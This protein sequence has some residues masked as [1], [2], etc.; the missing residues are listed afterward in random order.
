M[1][2]IDSQDIM[3]GTMQVSKW[4]NSLAVRLPKALVEELGLKEGDEL[5]VVAAKNGA[6]EVETKEDQR[7]RALDRMAARNWTLPEGY[8]FDRDEANE[9]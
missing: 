2:Y 9:R 8:R 1:I 7:R 6:I 5:S 4:G 3:E